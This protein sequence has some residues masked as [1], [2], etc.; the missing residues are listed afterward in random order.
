MHLQ[1]SVIGLG[2]FANTGVAF[3]L[4]VPLP[5]ALSV[6][7]ITALFLARSVATKYTINPTASAFAVMA[8]CGALNNGLDRLV[9]SWTTDY[10]FFAQR[11]AINLSDGLVVIGILGYLWYSEDSERLPRHQ[12]KANM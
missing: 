6:T 2:F 1:H 3:S 10:I 8:V 11:L 7:F 12:E 9:H 4:P 5:L